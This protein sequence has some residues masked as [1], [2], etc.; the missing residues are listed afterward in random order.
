MS[1]VPLD[2]DEEFSQQYSDTN[3]F[4][5]Q[6][7]PPAQDDWKAKLGAFARRAGDSIQLQSKAAVAK[8]QVKLNEAR[9]TFYVVSGKIIPTGDVL[10]HKGPITAERPAQT[11]NVTFVA[12]FWSQ[13]LPLAP[14]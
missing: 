4:A 7:Q 11:H 12:Y 1:H 2:D 5:P 13:S 9:G 14:Y 8:V 3:P 6:T 10:H